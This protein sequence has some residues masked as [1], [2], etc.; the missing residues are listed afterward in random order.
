[1]ERD[2]RR[3]QRVYDRA[4]EVVRKSRTYTLGDITKN[5]ALMFDALGL[6]LRRA[7]VGRLRL[8][9]AMS[10]SK[11]AEPYRI[12][13]PA[14][15]KHIHLLEDA[16]IVTTHKRGRIRFCVYKPTAFKELSRW[17]TSQ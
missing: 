12:T 6:P 4:Q 11:L 10:L 2:E 5:S 3:Q 8:G 13:L 16:G 17:L 1:M 9:G 7:M 14:A 15:L